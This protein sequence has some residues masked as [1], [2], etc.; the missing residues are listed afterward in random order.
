M[1][2]PSI[3]PPLVAIGASTGGPKVLADILSRFP[4]GLHA[5]I[6]IVQHVN[7]EFS[8]SLVQWLDTM[9]SLP[10][11]LVKEGIRPEAGTVYIAGTDDHLVFSSDL[12][13]SYISIPESPPFHPSIDIFFQSILPCRICKRLAGSGKKDGRC[14]GVLLSGMGKD[15]AKGLLALRKAGWHTIAQDRATSAV[16]GMPKAANDLDAADEILPAN[17][18]GPAIL[19]ALKGI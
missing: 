17:Q 19:R 9:T 10:V 2:P 15:G 13:F 12:T 16:Y 5:A 1:N 3:L 14:V 6:I 4:A 18:I 11:C 7:K 8:P